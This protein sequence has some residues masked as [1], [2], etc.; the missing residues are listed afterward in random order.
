[1]IY[2]LVCIL[3]WLSCNIEFEKVWVSFHQFGTT[4]D[5]TPFKRQQSHELAALHLDSLALPASP[6]AAEL[7][8]AFEVQRFYWGH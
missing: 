8:M 2:G 3:V 7:L 6:R 4:S 1:M 5:T